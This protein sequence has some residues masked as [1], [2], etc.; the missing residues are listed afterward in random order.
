MIEMGSK[1]EQMATLVFEYGLRNKSG[2]VYHD[3]QYEMRL[4][5]GVAAKNLTVDVSLFTLLAVSLIPASFVGEFFSSVF[6][7]Y[8]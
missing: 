2:L 8:S 4:M 5:R 1:L 6:S 3:S 7:E